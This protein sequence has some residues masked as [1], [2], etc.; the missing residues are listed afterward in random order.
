[1]LAEVSKLLAGAPAW[2][3]REVLICGGAA[4]ALLVISLLLRGLQKVVSVALAIALV[5]GAVWFIRDAWRHKDK[6]LSPSVAAQLDT[7]ADKTLSSPQAQAAWE[8][9]K[10]QFSRLSGTADRSASTV[11]EAQRREALA[12]ELTARATALRREGSKIAAEE[13]LRF[14]DK[15]RE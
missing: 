3:S 10:S 8:S 15:L 9:I 2:L 13:L 6:F 5:L 11:T 4:V 14:R 1:V 12:N 7:M